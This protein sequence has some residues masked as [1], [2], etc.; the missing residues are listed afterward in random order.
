MMAALPKRQREIVEFIRENMD[1]FGVPPTFREIAAHF[2][3]TVPTVQESI[4]SLEGKGV[5][6]RIPRKSRN[7]RLSYY[8]GTS[9]RSIPILGT[10]AAGTPIAAIENPDGFLAVDASLIQGGQVF[11]LKVKG[12]SMMEAGILDGDY[13]FVRVQPG[14]ENGEIGL[15]LID[16]GEAT[17][18]RIFK[19]GAKIELRS[20]NKYYPPMLLDPQRVRIQGKIIGIFRV[21][22]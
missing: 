22:N 2:R 11:A 19:Q 3:I 16:E 17:I 14:V 20:E 7:L 15:V 12:D 21:F 6:E 18:K 4:A 8:S 1:T 10:T 9:F 13:A 5:I